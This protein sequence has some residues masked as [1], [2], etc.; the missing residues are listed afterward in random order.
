V[1]PLGAS[2][3]RRVDVRIV[4]ASNRD[5]WRMVE[6]ARSGATSTIV[7][8]CSRSASAAPPATRRRPALVEHFVARF[9]AAH[10][11]SLAAPSPARSGRS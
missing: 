2:G 11:T 10:G 4:A 5:L 3:T 9:N 1:R 8:A 6:A 7:S